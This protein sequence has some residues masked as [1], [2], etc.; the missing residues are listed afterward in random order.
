MEK[1][2][3]HSPLH[4]FSVLR[5]FGRMFLLGG[6]QL[7]FQCIYMI[8]TYHFKSNRE[9]GDGQYDISLLPREKKYPGI[10]MELKWKSGLGNAELETLSI[11]RIPANKREAVYSGI[12]GNWNCAD[13]EAG[14][15]FL[16]KESSYQ[17]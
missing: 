17:G 9:S 16:W 4:Y 12:E 7:F 3:L 14:N 8:P 15:C 10:I 11:R 2:D 6:S 1:A 13:S 5:L